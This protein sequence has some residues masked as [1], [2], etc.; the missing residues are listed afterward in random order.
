MGI[1]NTFQAGRALARYSISISLA[2]QV[3][4]FDICGRLNRPQF[5]IP[6]NFKFVDKRNRKNNIIW[7]KIIGLNL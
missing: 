4:K 3:E 5:F 7:I 2:I 6:H 1:R